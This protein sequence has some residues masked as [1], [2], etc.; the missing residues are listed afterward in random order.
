MCN[1]CP[2]VLAKLDAINKLYSTYRPKNVAFVGINSN[3]NPDYPEDD[4]EHMKKFAYEK[5]I[6]FPY[7]FDETQDV[8]KAYG[9][10]CTPDPFVF[11]AS[12]RL[13]YH[14]R[15]DDAMSPGASPTTNDLADALDDIL[16]GR[17]P[18]GQF[19]PSRGCSIKWRE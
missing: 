16:V 18:K 15:I 13:A 19:K 5:Q 1:H 4:F 8:A 11:D 9:A 7:L 2:Y 6:K 17:V 3:N 12:M 14:G 10:V